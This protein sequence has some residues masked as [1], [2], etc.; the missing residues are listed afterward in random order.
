M[1]TDQCRA[2]E[3]CA[4][5]SRRSQ[6]CGGRRSRRQ[7]RRRGKRVHYNGRHHCGP[8]PPRADYARTADMRMQRATCSECSAAHNRDHRRPISLEP[9]LNARTAYDIQQTRYQHTPH[10]LT[11][12]RAPPRARAVGRAG[13]L[14]QGALEV[15]HPQS[16]VPQVQAA[17]EALRLAPEA[18]RQDRL[19]AELQGAD[20]ATAAA[21]PRRRAVYSYRS[22]AE[23]APP[24]GPRLTPGVILGYERRPSR[25]RWCTA[26][27]AAS[28]ATRSSRRSRWPSSRAGR[29]R[30]RAPRST[31][32][33]AAGGRGRRAEEGYWSTHCGR[34]GGRLR[35]E[36]NSD[37]SVEGERKEALVLALSAGGAGGRS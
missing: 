32:S 20:A 28:R 1:R 8:S 36:I 26:S 13:G 33:G 24:S 22:A 2:Q 21:T 6:P 18:L 30:G 10:P 35:R 9:I 15:F 4:G 14:R 23:A 25:R 29:A 17:A 31:R 27:R 12:E 16:G 7:A 34:A 11:P 3:P 5:E 19:E 37:V